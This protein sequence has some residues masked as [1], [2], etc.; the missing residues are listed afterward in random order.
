[1]SFDFVYIDRKLM[2]CANSRANNNIDCNGIM[3]VVTSQL[4]L[5]ICKRNHL[6][7]LHSPLYNTANNSRYKQS[8]LRDG[9]KKS[10]IS[11]N[12]MLAH[13]YKSYRK[14]LLSFLKYIKKVK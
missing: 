10:S 11:I 14:K 12:V 13:Y 9:I 3:L 5:S 1:M 6:P 4:D 2:G 8:G 7:P